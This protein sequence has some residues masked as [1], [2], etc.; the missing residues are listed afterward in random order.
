MDTS[1]IMTFAGQALEKYDYL[2][3][4][5]L[6]R[7]MMRREEVGKAISAEEIED[8]ISRLVAACFLDIRTDSDRE[9][10][11]VRHMPERKMK[12]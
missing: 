9:C 5:L 1:N 10:V 6:Q 11:Y 8:A 2:T 7:Y 12:C 3:V 4:P